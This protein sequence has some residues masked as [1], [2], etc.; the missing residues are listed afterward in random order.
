MSHRNIDLTYSSRIPGYARQLRNLGREA[1][2]SLFKITL[3]TQL[4]HLVHH[5]IQKRLADNHVEV[6]LDQVLCCIDY[7]ACAINA[8]DDFYIQLITTWAA[9]AHL[10]ELGSNHRLSSA[11]REAA[12]RRQLDCALA[13]APVP[14]IPGIPSVLGNTASSVVQNA[15][16]AYMHGMISEN[17][18]R[19]HMNMMD[20]EIMKHVYAL[21]PATFHPEERG[22]IPEEPRPSSSSHSNP[23]CLSDN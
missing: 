14:Q 21:K 23:G 22:V 19:M 8:F 13:I 16:A 10:S 3:K 11:E 12:I 1:T 17:G 5:A 4:Q 15:I 6:W 18:V 2:V 20:R 7:H 9:E